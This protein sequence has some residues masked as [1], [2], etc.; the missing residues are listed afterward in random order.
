[1]NNG[2]Q[3]NAPQNEVGESSLP[4]MDQL[5]PKMAYVRIDIGGEDSD[6]SSVSKETVSFSKKPQ[7]LPGQA[8]HSSKQEDSQDEDDSDVDYKDSV[9]ILVPEETASYLQRP[10]ALRERAGH[11]SKQE[12]S[13]VKDDSDVNDEID[14]SWVD[15]IIVSTTIIA[16]ILFL[17]LCD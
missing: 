14:I 16:I 3:F 10:Q 11:S 2:L 7:T 9:S 4:N 8:G 13:E 12:D 15:V 5:Q 6:S 17:I 1:M